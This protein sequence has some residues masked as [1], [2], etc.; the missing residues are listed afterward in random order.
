MSG[1]RPH[2][3]SPNRIG[4]TRRR[5]MRDSVSVACFGMLAACGC[6]PS[7]VKI[8]IVGFVSPV[9]ADHEQF[10]RALRGIGRVEGQSIT[11]ESRTEREAADQLTAA[12]EELV[13]LP[14]DVIAVAGTPAAQVAKGATRTIPIVFFGVGDPV[15]P[16]LVASLARPE[17]NVTGVTNI[18][19]QAI[20][21][22]LE[23]LL[24]LVPGTARVAFVGNLANNP[25]SLLQ[26][27][28]AQSVATT[29][30]VQIT[31]FGVRDAGDIDR[32]FGSF[33]A[34]GVKAVMIG[35]DAITIN[36]QPR[37][38]ELA[39]QYRLPA[40][41]S[42]REFALAGGLIALGPNYPA[43][44]VRLAVLVDKIIRGRAPGDLP[45][46]Q[47]TETALVVN[48]KTAQ[49]LGITIPRAILVQA[50]VLQ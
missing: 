26:L 28:A 37:L 21:K 12:V 43:L 8:P 33:S 9:N 3:D 6:V 10:R 30:G 42:R 4:W 32:V 25:G 40:I 14:A 38:V 41:Y 27:A 18:A 2:L 47:P 48:A 29:I 24:Q 35:S 11:F 17:G 5:V 1:D 22:G 50:E 36:N 7:A 49:A 19:P 44:W 15:T 20:G 34:A 16:G 46:E 45:V 23:Y 39:A 13:R 31:D